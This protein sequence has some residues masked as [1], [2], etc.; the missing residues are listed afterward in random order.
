MMGRCGGRG[1]GAM[2]GRWGGVAGA[3]G[4]CGRRCDGEPVSFCTTS[5][6]LDLSML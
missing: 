4:C 6:K 3:V 2:M 1:G 5:R